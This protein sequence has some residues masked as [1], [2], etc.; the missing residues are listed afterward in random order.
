MN[1]APLPPSSARPPALQPRPETLPDKLALWIAV[2]FGCGFVPR[3]PG[4]VGSLGALPLYALA[5][6]GGPVAV[7][8]AGALV[9][10]AGI[11]ASNRVARLLD[12]SDPQIIVVDEVAGVLLTL[13]VAPPTLLGLGLGFVL[14]RAFDQLKPWPV[15]HFERLPGGYGVMLDDVAA[16]GVAAVVLLALQGTGVLA[17]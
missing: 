1:G 9:T 7:F 5:S 2:W 4:T 6:R 13:A 12:K 3:A 17:L 10:L 8:A 14:F 15:R 11:W 16:A